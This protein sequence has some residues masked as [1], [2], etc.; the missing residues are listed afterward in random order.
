MRKARLGT[1]LLALWGILLTVFVYAYLAWLQPSRLGGTVSYALESTLGVRCDIGRVSLSLLPMPEVTIE[2]LSLHRGTLDHLEF[3]AR[4]AS[5]QVS[6]FSLLRLKP[7]V[8]TIALD[9]PTL[10]IS[11]AIMQKA[12]HAPQ[13]GNQPAIP[14]SVPDIPL[15]ITGLHLELSNGTCH[16][17]SADGR[18]SLTISG[19]NI[20]A[21]IPSLVPGKLDLSVDSIRYLLASGIDLS[22]KESRISIDSLF[23]G[24]DS[25]W[26]GEA[27]VSTALQLGSLD[28]AMGHR[29][30]DPYRYFPMPE[31]L[32]FS[33]Q[34]SFSADPNE[35]L[36][37]AVGKT[38]LTALLPMNG[39][40]VPISL[41]V[42]FSMVGLENGIAVSK[43]DVRMGDDRIVMD[44]I[45][46]G[47]LQGDPVLRGR[48]KVHHF[49]L[50][51]WFGFGRLMDPGLQFSLDDIRADFH[52]LN[53]S[54]KGVTVPR[55]T[56][57][58]QG[59]ELHGSGSCTEYLKPVVRIDAH[60]KTADL[61]RVFTELHGEFPDLSHLPP[62]VLPLPPADAP[63]SKDGI[64][65][66]YDIH[67]SADDAKIMN[68][69][70]GGA[71]VH[72]IP[73]PDY[74]TMLTIDVADVYGGKADSKVYIQDKIRV[75]ADLNSVALGGLSAALA[76]YPVLT[77]DLKSG[78]VDIS[79][80]PGNG[81]EMLTTLG[82]TVKA[83]MENGA[84]S[85]KDSS[86]LEYDSFLVDAQA[87]ASSGKRSK[88]MP[89]S[90]D[91]TGRWNASLDAKTWSIHADAA[92]ATLGFSTVYGL[93]CIFREQP[94]PLQLTLKK[95]LCPSF[96]KD[97][98]FAITGKTS[99]NAEKGTLTLRQSTAE[100]QDFRL[101]GEAFFT[102]IFKKPSVSGK[103]SLLSR[104]VKQAAASFGIDLPAPDGSKAF[105]EA[106]LQASYAVSA[107]RVEFSELSGTLDGSSVKGNILYDWSGRHRIEGRL[108]TPFLDLDLY[109][110]KD[111]GNGKSGNSPAEIP[112]GFLKQA[113]MRLELRAE[114][115][116]ALS[117]QLSQVS[118]P[119]TQK[120]GVLSAPISL[121]FPSGG[122]ASGHFKAALARDG[123]HADISLQFRAP[124]INMLE[125]YRLREHKTVISGNGSA[126]LALQST[127]R[128][129]DDWKHTLDGFFSFAVENG[130]IISPPSPEAISAGR[131]TPSRTEF[132]RM[133]MSGMVDHG[134]I[135]CSDFRIVDTMLDVSG[136]GTIDLAKESIDA[137]ATIT[138]AGIPEMPI[139]LKGNMFAPET[140]YKLLGAVTGTVGNIGATIVDLVGTVVTAPFKL[141]S[142]E[143]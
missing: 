88:K 67:I 52:E 2:D 75:V 35:G 137:K 92:K 129:W 13:E 97:I 130:A 45:I 22:A 87:E 30:S 26:E 20:H 11:G 122:K 47:I 50:T 70:V 25:E 121:L 10:D 44:G 54:L 131:K 8:R 38:A 3:S 114:R 141:F 61:N 59:I 139:E 83:V 82:G 24:L 49:S 76:G 71:D 33:L 113:D 96:R 89:P 143:K 9:S 104:D 17:A 7:I 39:H 14:L 51:R 133:S 124:Q 32:R 69:R 19:L 91:F 78:D 118:L 140:N 95:V 31:P 93:P 80:D 16:F 23:K 37:N 134:V 85:V 128:Y 55:L 66:G 1:V 138:L 46:S 126:D 73:A 103:A 28:T 79:F 116:R 86:P 84:I 12:L 64:T 56:A 108:A 99:F 15:H 107:G 127:Q 123:R 117:A 81:V 53:L 6:W 135:S 74:G 4:R 42:P 115:L 21:V 62:P 132:K 57:F 41:D 72:V 98:G 58:V 102:D 18:D 65:V 77:G 29:I 142:G 111:D 48:A 40:D 120:N 36:L 106:D 136:G 100:T 112:L 90:V 27:S 34:A 109:L 110:P 125:F 94:I 105:K 119:V 68:F 5:V 60:A 101:S 63:T 43:A